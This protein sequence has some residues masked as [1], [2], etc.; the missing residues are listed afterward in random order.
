M[1]ETLKENAD[2]L[3]CMLKDIGEGL[4]TA[5]KGIFKTAYAVLIF[6]CSIWVALGNIACTAF[7]MFCDWTA[8]RERIR[9][10]GKGV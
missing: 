6:W 7:G 8:K 1:K 5:V 2:Y 9:H 3:W 10:Y 4:W